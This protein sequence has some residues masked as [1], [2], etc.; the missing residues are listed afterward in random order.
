MDTLQKARCPQGRKIAKISD[1]TP[2]SIIISIK[3]IKCVKS[4]KNR[5][6]THRK[7]K[8]KTM[9]KLSH[10][11]LKD[12]GRNL[13]GYYFDGNIYAHEN[14]LHY[15]T[16]LPYYAN[17]PERVAEVRHMNPEIMGLWARL[18]ALAPDSTNY[19]QLAYSCGIYGNSGQLHKIDYYKNGEIVETVYIFC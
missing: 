5:L 10:K 15:L 18:E 12:M 8:A 19:T 2:K 1:E 16:M 9:T 3:C 4:A 17:R 13:S 7:G 14:R 6:K 11:A